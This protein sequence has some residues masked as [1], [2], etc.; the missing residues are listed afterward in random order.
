MITGAAQRIGAA[1][2][3]YLHSK[4]FSIVI[5]YNRSA[6]E[7]NQLADEFNRLRA[8]SCCT[9][10]AD[11]QAASSY[12]RVIDTALE[13]TGSLDALVNNASVFYPTRLAQ[14]EE[15][16]WNEI[17]GTNLKAPLFLA[18]RA[19][20]HLEQTRGCIINITDIHGSRPLLQHS[21]YS[22]A[23]SGLN[24][25]TRCLAR[26]LAPDVRVN[27]VSPGAI[28]WPAG[29]QEETKDTILSTIPLHR[30]GAPLDIARAV[31]FLIAEADYITGQILPVDGGRS[32]SE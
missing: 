32:L 9:V 2:A 16:S 7:A 4:Q 15:P 17:I 28:L 10:Q 21:M 1:I 18:R 25:L 26:E 22:V 14:I 30:L 11:L 3:R 29:M 31:Y 27:A 19:A 24:M 5:H 20:P 12:D 23:K 6:K 8:N 13:L